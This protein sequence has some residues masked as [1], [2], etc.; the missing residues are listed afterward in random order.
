M[1]APSPTTPQSI[2]VMFARLTLANLAMV[3]FVTWLGHQVS[4]RYAFGVVALIGLITIFAIKFFLPYM[5]SL[6][7]VG[8]KEELEFFKSIKLLTGMLS[9]KKMVW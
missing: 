9:P 3:P 1:A 6:R 8:I 7:T 2:A 4:W 5:D